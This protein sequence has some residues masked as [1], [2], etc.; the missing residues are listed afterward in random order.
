MKKLGL[1]ILA[2]LLCAA[3]TACAAADV[4]DAYQ[5]ALDLSSV[6]ASEPAPT[7]TPSPSPTPKPTASPEPEAVEAMSPVVEWPEGVP[8][9]TD[10]KTRIDEKWLS[11]GSFKAQ[12][13]VTKA[14]LSKWESAMSAAGFASSPASAA[15]WTVSWDRLAQSGGDYRLSVEITKAADSP[16]TPSNGMPEGFEAFPAYCGVGSVT[17]SVATG[18]SGV[19]QLILTSGGETQAGLKAYTDALTAAGFQTADGHAY[20]KTAGS[21]D[22]TAYEGVWVDGST[23]RMTLEVLG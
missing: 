6:P 13:L 9:V 14:Q 2:L 23:M 22:Y 8:A 18:A 11:D 16:A 17:Y 12:F 15:G 3:L 21:V 4:D 10:Y 5:T 7:P 20:T 19:K 1:I